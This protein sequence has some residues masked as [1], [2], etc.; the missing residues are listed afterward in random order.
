M[1]PTCA[2]CR[3]PADLNPKPDTTDA[4]PGDAI[5]CGTCAGGN[6]LRPDGTLRV[7]TIQDEDAMSLAAFQAFVDA[8]TDVLTRNNQ[9]DQR[10]S[11]PGGKFNVHHFDAGA[12][13]CRCGERQA[14]GPTEAPA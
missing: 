11:C 14:A 10:E 8:R 1:N 7:V 9:R 4:Q 3:A 12:A 13:T 6:I 5:V 2:H